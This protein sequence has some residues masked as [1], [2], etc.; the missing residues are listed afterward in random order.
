MHY[1]QV[2]PE[3]C[4]RRARDVP[5]GARGVPQVVLPQVCPRCV[6]CPKC[7]PGVP[8]MCPKCAPG[9]PQVCPGCAPGVHRQITELPEYGLA[10]FE[11]S[12]G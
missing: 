5:Q 12:S 4:P 3:T 8:Q 2:V 11:H 10:K 9:V 1:S 6:L 7:A